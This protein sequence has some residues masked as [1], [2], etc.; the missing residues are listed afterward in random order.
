LS[1][2][3][4]S[5]YIP[6]IVFGIFLIYWFPASSY[7]EYVLAFLIAFF[8]LIIK[9][10]EEVGNVKREYIDS[11]L[12]LGITEKE[13]AKKVIWESLQPAVLKYITVLHFNIWSV[14]IVFEF[15]KGGYGLGNI[16]RIALNYKDL[17][18]LFTVSIIISLVIF[19]I[20][21]LIHYVKRKFHHWSF[22]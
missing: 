12:S 13:I 19:L 6:G 22:V 17:S 18:A 15:I 16:Y 2:H 11:A 10:R 9:L 3:W 7:I 20:N 8:S 4:F 21:I 1:L 5:V 14:L